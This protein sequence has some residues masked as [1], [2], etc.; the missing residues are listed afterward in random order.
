MIGLTLVGV[1]F[2]AFVFML[3]LQLRPPKP[4]PLVMLARFDQAQTVA[5]RSETTSTSK[6]GAG[7]ETRLGRWVVSELARRGIAYTSLRQDL[8]LNGQ[9]FEATMGRKVVVGV[10]GFLIGLVISV[11]LNVA[12]LHLPVGVPVVVGLLFAA[13]FFSSPTS[14]RAPRPPAGAKSSSAR[15]APTWTGCRCR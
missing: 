7:M 8:A 14:T 11:S 3:I 15:W 12:G 5:A 13:A 10:A 2:G 6:A 9:S 4:D 1:A